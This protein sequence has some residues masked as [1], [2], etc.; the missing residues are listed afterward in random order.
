MKNKPV[1][2][3]DQIRLI[4][5]CR[6]SGL[7]DYQWCEQNGV[8]AGTFYN[9][10]SKLRKS[11]YTFP[12]AK[13]KT[14]AKPNIQEVVKVDIVDETSVVEQNVSM[15]VMSGNNSLAAELQIGNVTL[16]LFNGADQCVI[17]NTLKY[18]G[19]GNHAW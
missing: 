13:G 7:S 16:R 6:K 12:D 9:W 17:Q 18:L 14:K 1:C 2:K 10:V 3:A 11:G 8:H 19:G 5:E 15:P 4:M